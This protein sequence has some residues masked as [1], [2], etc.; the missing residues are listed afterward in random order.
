M[1]KA[2]I[3]TD[4]N[5]F[6][7]NSFPTK[8]T[9]FG[10]VLIDYFDLNIFYPFPSNAN[11]VKSQ[12]MAIGREALYSSKLLFDLPQKIFSEIIESTTASK[13]EKL[14][15]KNLNNSTFSII[16]NFKTYSSGSEV[17]IFL[18]LFFNSSCFL[19]FGT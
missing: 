12:N 19:H 17:L 2:G 1:F 8:L 4:F 6:I 9:S 16:S 7:L 11:S 10:Y 13:F 18:N 15:S 3:T 14:K 5:Q